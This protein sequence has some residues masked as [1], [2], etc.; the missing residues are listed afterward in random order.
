VFAAQEYVVDGVTVGSSEI[1]KLLLTGEVER[2]SSL[3]G[4]PYRLQ[5]VV[6]KGDGRGK[7]L[8]YPTANIEPTSRRKLIPGRGVYLVGVEFDGKQWFG[9]MNIGRR[10]TVVHQDH[11]TV[12]V[13]VFSL[14]YDIYGSRVDVTFLKRLRE[15]RRFSSL[16]ELAAQLGKDKEASLQYLSE[17]H[18]KS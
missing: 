17:I 16:E 12:E 9:M 18:K 3:L 8:G 6:V 11:E 5:G 15:E 10:P 7:L 2:A 4:Y 1:R 14:E 13:N